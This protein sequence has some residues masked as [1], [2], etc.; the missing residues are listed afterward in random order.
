MSSLEIN[1]M[2]AIKNYIEFRAQK[3]FDVNKISNDLERAYY[4]L[5][6]GKEFNYTGYD[7]TELE[8][9]V[10]VPLVKERLTVEHSQWRRQ[11]Q[12]ETFLKQILLCALNLGYDAGLK[13]GKLDGRQKAYTEILKAKEG[14]KL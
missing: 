7:L 12:A 6:R 8:L 5:R 13:L 10:C 11:D 4:N 3:G 9:T 2:V 1:T 14:E